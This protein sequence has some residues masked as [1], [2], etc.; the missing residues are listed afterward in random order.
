[1]KFKIF[2]LMFLALAAC[3]PPEA[4]ENGAIRYRTTLDQALLLQPDTLVTAPAENPAAVSI[5]LDPGQTFQ[6]M[7]GFG[8]T[9]TGGSALNLQ[10][11]QAGARQAL[12]EELFGRRPEAIGISY[13]RLSVGASD[14]DEF[15]WSY[16]DRPAGETDPNLE[17]FS[18]GYDTLYLIPTLKEILEIQP[19][20]TLMGSP[21][22]PPAW[23]KDNKDTRGGSL[24]PEYY[25]AYAQYFVKYLQGMAGHGIRID[26]ITVQN[27][28]LHPGNNP[29]L[30]M[31]AEAQ[32]DFIA[33][34][35]G[36]AFKAAGITTK[37][38][39]Y[40]H[41]ADKP[42]Y[43]IS[44]LDRPD[45]APFI[46]GSAF[47]LYGG[48]I[49]ALSQVHAR[50]PSKHLYFTEQWIGAPGDFA[51]NVAWHT[52]NLMIGAPNNW[53][54]VVLQWNLA[55]DENQDPHT[56]RG[57]CDRCLGGVTLQG[58]V[59]TRNPAYY[60]VAQSSKFIPPGS[61]R[62]GSTQ[63]EGLNNVAY[64]TP[65]GGVALLLQNTS[66]TPREVA[67]SLGG[68]RVQFRMEAGEINTVVWG[69]GG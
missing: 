10:R 34:H 7:D 53:A 1:M 42:E 49:D 12:L 13:L 20:I 23:M 38:V 56:D 29:S 11:M 68:T 9:L 47:H 37:I 57:G 39:I 17:H 31:P 66:G 55:A 43:P 40:D 30:Y 28:P 26:A 3:H 4:E 61:V 15:P 69:S 27:E 60:I 33:N 63:P 16:N 8:F 67:V 18:L 24:L 19:G 14:L 6:T 5:T 44:I 52:E 50:H 45:A 32:A 41:N 62:M 2:P 36:P 46:D 51:D 58:D 54:K 25:P 65:D 59:V 35:L 21:W 22:S 64:H 48:S